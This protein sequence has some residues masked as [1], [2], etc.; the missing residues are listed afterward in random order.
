MT[1]A[2]DKMEMGTE[3]GQRSRIGDYRLSG[4]LAFAG[5][6]RG[7][8]F[9]AERPGP[10][11]SSQV[12]A[13]KL[14]LS[15]GPRRFAAGGLAGAAAGHRRA[16]AP[17]CG[18]HAG[19][20]GDRWHRLRG[21][22]I[23][24]RRGSDGGVRPAGPGR[25]ASGDRPGGHPAVPVHPAQGPGGARPVA[26]LGAAAR[27]DSP[28]EHPGDLRRSH[29]ADGLRRPAGHRAA[30]PGL[31]CPRTAAGRIGRPPERPVQHGRGA[32]G[33]AGR[34]AAVR[35]RRDRRRA[36]GHPRGDPPPA[37]SLAAGAAPG[38][39]RRPR[40]HRGPGAGAGSPASLRQRTG[41]GPG[42][43]GGGSS[44]HP[45]HRRGGGAVAARTVR[46][47]PGPVAASDRR[48]CGGR[49]GGGP[50]GG[51]HR[52]ATGGVGP[53][54]G[55]AQPIATA[56]GEQPDA[57]GIDGGG[58]HAGTH[59][60]SGGG[61]HRSDRRTPGAGAGA[62]CWSWFPPPR[63]PASVRRSVRGRASGSPRRQPWSPC[64]AWAGGWL[65]AGAA[66]S[67]P[68]RWSRPSWRRPAACA[69][70][71]SRPAPTS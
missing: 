20:R 1:G 29:P 36:R 8:S 7:R 12:V 19:G 43:G 67:I 60:G 13:L 16:A 57:G 18:C 32:V 11:G 53:P 44:L 34:Q 22:G 50:T 69:S 6:T 49:R 56:V 66:A 51:D 61:G 68:E 38:D 48:G 23:C 45:A 37:H 27:G 10:G 26:A 54:A 55:S 28:F 2:A 64:W 63:W 9:V 24:R 14:R 65:P 47:R 3:I 30:R 42:A 15:A 33:G 21:P 4:P 39:P 59:P 41:D 46:G 5:A 25:P 35:R 71:A 52:R 17:A 31:R 62:P 40:G 70:R 58:D